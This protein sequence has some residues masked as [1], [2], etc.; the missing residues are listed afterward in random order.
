MAKYNDFGSIVYSTDPNFSPY[1]P[2][3]EVGTLA[4]EKQK[5]RLRYE[6]AGRG[7]KEATLVTGFVGNDEDLKELTK[8]LKQSLGCGGSCKEGDIIIQGNKKDKAIEL[9]LKWGYK[10]TK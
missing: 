10:N 4:P 2:E 5:L 9:L 1:E 8:K 6:R 7:G 3:E